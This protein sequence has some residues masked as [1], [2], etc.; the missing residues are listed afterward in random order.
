MTRE[1]PAPGSIV[2]PAATLAEFIARAVESYGSIRSA[3]EGIGIPYSTLRG[4]LGARFRV[5]SGSS[6]N[7]FDEHL[8]GLEREIAAA[9]ENAA[10]AN[11][12]A[13][14]LRVRIDTIKRITG[15]G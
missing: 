1:A 10:A 8:A 11:E 5:V 4:W 9:N 2:I 3:A 6:S 7:A 15:R 12:N 14:A 13:A